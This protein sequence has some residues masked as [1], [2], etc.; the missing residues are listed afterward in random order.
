MVTSPDAAVATAATCALSLRKSRATNRQSHDTSISAGASSASDSIV[1]TPAA[2]AVSSI[3]YVLPTGVSVALP[4]P[5]GRKCSELLTTLTSEAGEATSGARPPAG[6]ASKPYVTAPH[7]EREGEPVADIVPVSDALEDPV[8]AALEVPVLVPEGEED[9][10][11]EWVAVMLGVI[12]H[13]P[14]ALGEPV[15]VV[16]SE[17]ELVALHERL[18]VPLL[19]IVPDELALSVVLRETV[20]LPLVDCEGD[21]DKLTDRVSL[22]LGELVAAGLREPVQLQ[23]AP[24][25]DSKTGWLLLGD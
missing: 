3:M 22:E 2:P 11:A 8:L 18:H 12:V 21:G 25:I 23:E 15:P 10:V 19:E 4:R 16:L 1:G 24:N 6:P 7:G 5:P 14:E 13:V 17:A 20:A 9:A